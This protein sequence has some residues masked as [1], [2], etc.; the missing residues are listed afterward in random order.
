MA[1]TIEYA[2]MAGRAY[3]STRG[4]INW[5]PVPDGWTEFFHV[6][7][8][9]IPDFQATDG[10]EAV[11]FQ[12]GSE[13]V[14]SFAGTAGDG[15]WL[16]G[17]FP[18]ALGM[19]GDQLEQAADYYLKVKAQ[20][21]SATISFTGHSLG[22]GLA[23][24]MAV[25]FNESATTFDQAPFAA[26]ALTYKDAEGNTHSAAQ[27]L[28]TYLQSEV[29]ENGQ[30]V[31]TDTQLQRLTDYVNA[32][33][34]APAGTIPNAANVSNI[35]VHGEILG[36]LPQ[37][38]I[39]SQ[40]D[41]WQ[42]NNM[43]IPF[44]LTANL[45][46]QT[47]L[48]AMLQSG[49]LPSVTEP[50]GTEHTLGRVSYKLTDLLKMIFDGSLFAHT[51]AISNTTDANFLERIVRH[52]TG[53]VDGV[54]AGGDA[55]V[56]RFTSD[57][58]KLA[59][60]GGMTLRDGNT[61]PDIHDLSNALIAFAMQK[62]YEE[63]AA[64]AGYRKGLFTDLATAGEGSGGIRFD[65]ADVSNRL[66]AAA[67]RNER[68]NLEEKDGK[69]NYYLKGYQYLK[70]YLNQDNNGL[71]EKDRQ[72]IQSL[73]PYMRDWYVQAGANGMNATDTLS[74]NAF[75]LGGVGADVL[76]GG[77]GSDLLVGN[78]GNDKLNGGQGHD[79]LLGGAGADTYVYGTGGGFDIVLDS[80][81]SGTLEINGQTVTGGAQYGDARVYKG[82]DA[83]G[84]SHSYVFVN[85]NAANGG[86]LLVD[87]HILIKDYQDSAG[88]GMG[89]TWSG[90][91]TPSE[92]VTTALS[93]TP[94]TLLSSTRDIDPFGQV[95]Y[96]DTYS[97]MT[98]RR[99]EAGVVVQN[100]FTHETSGNDAITT[101]DQRDWINLVANTN[102]AGDDVIDAGGGQ[103]YIA[104]GSGDDVLIGGAGG[105]VL[106]AGTGNDRLYAENKVE[107]A[108]AIADGNTT[109]ASTAKGDFLNA[110][111]GNDTLVGSASQ[112]V[113]FGGG[114]EDLLIGG[115]GDDLLGG[116]AQGY[117]EYFYI[118][119]ATGYYLMNGM[120]SEW[121]IVPGSTTYA[122]RV[123]GLSS[124]ST[125]DMEA[126]DGAADVIYAGA[127]NDFSVGYNG[128]D[129]IFGEDGN[130][131]LL[132]NGG[133]HTVAGNDDDYLDGGKGNDV[134][135]GD[136][137]DDVLVGGA[138]ADTLIGGEGG[139]VYIY[140]AGDGID[141]I[142]DDMSGYNTLRFGTGVNATDIKLRLGSLMLDLGNGNAIHIESFDR[143]DALNSSTIKSFEFSGGST[144]STTELLA[145]GF[146]IDGT[147]GD[148][149]YTSTDPAQPPQDHTLYGTNV[150]DR[151]RG[152]GGNDVLDAGDGDD[153][154][155]G[156]DGADTLIGGSGND[157][158]LGGAGADV[159]YA[160]AVEPYAA[161]GGDD[162]L[163][164]GEG[165][166]RLYGGSGSTLFVCSSGNDT[167]TGGSGNNTYQFDPGF[168][169]VR[170]NPSN[171]A[172]STNALVFGAGIGL[173][174]LTFKS[175]PN[176]EGLTD[177]L[178]TRAGGGSI[179]VHNGKSDYSTSYTFSDGQTLR[180]QDLMANGNWADPPPAPPVSGTDNYDMNAAQVI[181]MPD[182]GGNFAFDQ[183][184][185]SVYLDTTSA[186]RWGSVN[187]S[188]GAG[189]T[190]D[191]LTFRPLANGSGSWAA[192]LLI[193]DDQ[194]NSLAIEQGIEDYG[195][196][197]TFADGKTLRLYD[198]LAQG[199]WGDYK[200]IDAA[201]ARSEFVAYM[202]PWYAN[203]D[204][205][206]IDVGDGNAY[207]TPTFS[208][209]LVIDG[210]GSS[211]IE[212][213]WTAT[214]LGGAGDDV[215]YG[216][217]VLFD[218]AGD[219]HIVNGYVVYGG[220][221]NDLIDDV[222]EVYFGDGNDTIAGSYV[223]Y[224]G[225]GDDLL[226][227]NYQVYAGSGNDTVLR[228]GSIYVN[229]QTVGNLLI[230]GKCDGVQPDLNITGGLK[231]SDLRVSVG[232]AE[233][234]L[235]GVDYND[236]G[237]V[238]GPTT[239]PK[240]S[241]T[242]VDIDWGTAQR[243][244][245]IMAQGYDAVSGIYFDDGSQ[246][247]VADLMAMVPPAPPPQGQQTVMGTDGADVLYS[248]SNGNDVFDG[249]AGDD[250]IY[251]G[252]PVSTTTS[253]TTYR[254]GF[255]SG[256][257]TVFEVMVSGSTVGFGGGVDTIQMAA[258][259]L[260]SDVTPMRDGNNNLVLSLTGGADTLTV[261]G[262]YSGDLY[263]VERVS[264]ADG[265]V[266]DLTQMA[267]TLPPPA[268]NPPPSGTSDPTLLAP[269]M[270][271]TDDPWGDYLPGTDGDDVISGLGGD[272]VID[273][274]LGDDVLL[275]GAGDDFMYGGEGNDIYAGGAGDD[276][277]GVDDTG[278]VVIENA[279]E[280]TDTVKSSVSYTL[281]VNV[282]N[283]TLAGIAAING[284]GNALDN[285]LIGNSENNTL[286]GGLGNDLLAGESGNDTY[287][288]SRGSGGDTIEEY[289]STTAN[290]D[291]AQF[292][293]AIS[294]D[295]LWFRQ[296]GSNLEVSI[297]GTSDSFTV[298]NW[299]L[300]SQY[301]VE[302]FKTSDGK[303]LLDSQVQ[304]L[305]SAM[306]SFTPPA[307][308]QTT[309][310]EGYAAALNPVI[311]ANWQ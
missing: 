215:I 24:L 29:D 80:D 84:Q 238:V 87:N 216:P 117:P 176:S 227:D 124:L 60:D 6:P 262:W 83:N 203:L 293:S 2:L 202:S 265:T 16:H 273:G 112:D 241:Y 280:G 206:V 20:N 44:D 292:G 308:G 36:Y 143:N 281:G 286:D 134:L 35:N 15:D 133:L 185:G 181:M 149:A 225:A 211:T 195:A 105:D 270:I 196:N 113:L 309:L 3:L 220:A 122:K 59:Q 8:P 224:D 34:T 299:Y 283:L 212:G 47:L 145:R 148:D 246:A 73:L 4:K 94:G 121:S 239:Q 78:R 13:I 166:D 17:N 276:R 282:E 285:L 12:R 177:L 236:S 91:Q 187:V 311:V 186:D 182:G 65:M 170:L 306:A 228:A 40:A 247:S 230:G 108:Q 213:G 61:N 194:G 19:L 135:L 67:G 254:F 102:G 62:Y 192:D 48:T 139:D 277:Y 141:K 159:L 115:A 284:T 263:Q 119:P 39:G 70:F 104:S 190:L 107:L 38:R 130:D 51:T 125:Y 174:D 37:D 257:D 290:M 75:M 232:Q 68:F 137:G 25:M 243:V 200:P 136:I 248:S 58:W 256:K 7:D 300:G 53:G 240:L 120:S 55:M 88:N 127:G 244:R 217:R 95:Y 296:L 163:D 42:Q 289:D 214:I 101:G 266:W 69:G 158:L 118:D 179:T 171:D 103:D 164:G 85:D 72:L 99:T 90:A 298:T 109:A 52:Q 305:V 231:L 132:G 153:W 45:H 172:G 123:E 291:T 199:Q 268:S 43:A 138:G 207:V 226:V 210:A 106:N 233:V 64:S 304:D 23:S 249:G 301:H 223:V 278:E 77:M 161:A 9:N 197:F 251:A 201:T 209:P 33:S 180:L 27:D 205:A 14:I 81:N 66:A 50:T 128:N 173:A 110:M 175:V 151:I 71:A 1:T 191:N 234:A 229:P 11:S 131:T 237:N 154:L 295:Q 89:L 111:G 193:V 288:L 204:G 129:I 253:D 18:Q 157:A 97:N 303:T 260:P 242:T 261:V 169:D 126:S 221:G 219:D 82:V 167:M 54:P 28:L 302:Q 32:L 272:D 258:G 274:H 162:R 5:F 269:T 155:D 10:F 92:P 294:M 259:V 98:V 250:T 271:G 100:F 222:S 116:D 178:V 245:L 156:G 183:G 252:E 160:G 208:N 218:G 21:P 189:I 49:D 310:T 267:A 140:N 147:D 63:T 142:E 150:N 188:F 279:D 22:G 165:D 168:G 235:Q 79:V 307:M 152:F 287:L 76:S 41:L 184:M 26:S 57:L 255:G 114:G 31:Y 144:L 74:R 297:I 56:T 46:S 86:D 198:L 30:R 264:F 93:T 146:D 96:A 275:G